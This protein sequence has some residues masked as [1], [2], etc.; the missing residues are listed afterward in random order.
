MKYI[1]KGERVVVKDPARIE[2]GWLRG[3]EIT[4][5]SDGY[6]IWTDRVRL[7]RGGSHGQQTG[8]QMR[9][10]ANGSSKSPHISQTRYS[11]ASE[12]NGGAQS[13]R[14]SEGIATAVRHGYS[15]QNPCAQDTYGAQNTGTGDDPEPKKPERRRRNPS[16]SLRPHQ[17]IQDIKDGMWGEGGTQVKK[18]AYYKVKAETIARLGS[19]ASHVDRTP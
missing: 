11:L 6:T 9:W 5:V 16:Q 8:E 7:A 14:P 18:G 13:H 15:T 4:V 12:Q 19:R 17:Y 2:D 1:V 10:M 3:T